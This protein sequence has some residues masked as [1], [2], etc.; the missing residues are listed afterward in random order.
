MR[1]SSN[2]VFKNELFKT[3]TV[4]GQ[5][6]T[7][8]GTI[9]KTII[10]LILA[11]VTATWTWMRFSSATLVSGNAAAGAAAGIAAVQPYMI[12]GLIVGLILALAAFFKPHTAPF[13]APMYAIAE[14]FALGGL[15]AIFEVRYPGIV[16]QAVGL[17]FATM[18]VMLFLYR[19]RIIRVTNKLRTGIMAATGGILLIYVADMVMGFF[20]SSIG[21]ISSASPLGIGFSLLVVGI[22]AFNLLLDFDF[23]ERA[24]AN[25]ASQKMEWLGALALMVTLVWLYMELLRL[26]SKLRR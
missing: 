8:N 11:M 5:V 3:Q 24:S 19:S 23:I 2:P 4:D 18:A 21:I 1:N 6:M 9:N 13:T 22:A 16:I 20:G 10:L 26:L 15:S 17:T 7:V 25:G 12:G 14:G